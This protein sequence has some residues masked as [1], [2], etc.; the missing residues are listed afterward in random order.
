MILIAARRFAGHA[1]LLSGIFALAFLTPVETVDSDPAIALLVSQVILDHH[2]LRLDVYRDDPACAYDLENDYRIRHR[3]DHLYYYA[4]GVPILSLPFVWVANRLGFH[5]LDQA[6]EQTA[7]NLLSALCCAAIFWLLYL[8]CRAYLEPASSLIIVGVSVLGSPLISTVATGLWSSD[9]AALFL[10]LAVLC[11]ARRDKAQR[12]STPPSKLDL[13]GLPLALGTAFFARP[14][15]GFAI[16]ALLVYLLTEPDRRV[17]RVAA[18]I[19]GLGCVTILASWL[20][21]VRWLPVPFYYLSPTRLY[22]ETRLAVGLAGTLW[23]PSRGLLVFCPF[24]VLVLAGAAW[25]VFDWRRYRLILFAMV[26]IVLHTV[27]VATRAVWWGGYS[28]GP[29]LF[30]ELMP[31]FVLLTALLWHRFGRPLATTPKTVIATLYLIPGLLAIIIHSFQGLFN[32]ATR[33]WNERPDIDVYRG[34]LVDWRYP[35]FLATEA[36]LESRIVDFQRRT[37]GTYQIGQELAHDTSNAL[38]HAWYPPET[39]WRWSRG[40][41]PAI[42]LKLGALPDAPLYLLGLRAGS[43]VPQD[44]AVEINGIAIGTASYDGFATKWQLLGVNPN[45]LRPLAENTIELTVP[46]PGGTADDPRQLGIALRSLQLFPLPA[47]FAGVD[48]REDAYFLQGFSGAEAGW[49]WSDGS[50]AS[51]AYPIGDAID[52]PTLLRLT[53]GTLGRQRV[54]VFL[55]EQPLGDLVFEG[56]EPKTH[57][58]EI[59]PGMIRSHR[60]HHIRLATPDAV[61]PPGE[62]RQ[63]GLAFVAIE[64]AAKIPSPVP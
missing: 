13:Y 32:P 48:Y 30:T 40:S 35:Q 9:Y 14:S 64:L 11:L 20:G 27:G 36:T 50:Q 29:R 7:Q 42:T 47:D 52:T 24:L 56:F 37:L 8:A 49:R 12:N 39:D 4:P 19:L 1:A 23:S 59:P 44:L 60:L 54:Q 34:A 33:Q 62:T 16:L 28:Y 53:A 45:L 5:M 41:S 26:W 31:A 61:V 57:S 3:G 15:A 51:I 2:T 22:P 25:R 21:W 63:L 38:F 58:I 6:T 46:N 18:G 17:A 55:D 10:S 43:L